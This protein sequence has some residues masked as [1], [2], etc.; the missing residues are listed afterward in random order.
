MRARKTLIVFTAT[1]AIAACSPGEAATSETTG[2]PTTVAVTSTTIETATTTQ[3]AITTSAVPGTTATT[4]A[5]S[6]TL[7]EPTEVEGVVIAVEGGLQVVDSFTI[8]IGAGE[9]MTFDPG[10]G[11]LFDGGPLSHLREHLAD[12]SPVYVVYIVEAD[13]TNVAIEVGDAD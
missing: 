9:Q 3:V 1:L 10:P 8:L 4:V 12:G 13:G 7:A 11:L 2:S 5:P 6:T